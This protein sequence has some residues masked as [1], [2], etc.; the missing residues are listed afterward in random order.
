MGYEGYYEIS[1]LGRLKSFYRTCGKPYRILR[2]S[3]RKGYYK[4]VLC[5]KGAKKKTAIIH[6][7][8]AQAW[9]P[10]PENKLQ[11]NHKDG[12]KL[13]NKV[14]NLEWCTDSE[15]Q[16]HSYEMLDRKPSGAAI[17]DWLIWVVRTDK[18]GNQEIYKG[19]NGTT[20]KLGLGKNHIRNAI[21]HERLS[22]EYYWRYATNDEVKQITNGRDK[23]RSIVG[24]N[25]KVCNRNVTSPSTV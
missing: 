16:K 14:V 15:N 24:K 21:K 11:V 17:M 25:R 12:N 13:N 18:E 19:V 23:Q 9:I 2:L 20:K 3:I 4:N 1:N 10:N 5:K 8:V 7:L 22:M 6:R